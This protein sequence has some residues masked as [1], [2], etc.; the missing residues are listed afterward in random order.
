MQFSGRA[1][2]STTEEDEVL[3]E[4]EGC[5]KREEVS[6]PWQPQNPTIYRGKGGAAPPP[7]FPPLGVAASP[8]S[9]LGGR[10]RGGEGETCPPN[11]V[12]RPLPKP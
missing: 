11:K 1:S 5:V 8:R 9:H 3:E 12:G 7:R 2:P 4:G 6:C 10:P